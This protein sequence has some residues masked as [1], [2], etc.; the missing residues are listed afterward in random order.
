MKNFLERYH[1][2]EIFGVLILI[3][4]YIKFKGSDSYTTSKYWYGI[5]PNIV[6]FIIPIQ[7]L[8][9]IGGLYWVYQIRKNKPISGLL[10][11]KL[12]GESASEILITIFTVASLIWPWTLPDPK[13]IKLSKA[14]LNT[15]ALWIAATAA[16]LAIAGTFENS[17]STEYQIVA[18]ILFS[19]TIVL[20]DGIGWSANLLYKAIHN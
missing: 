15:S 11:Y 10:T 6:K 4:Y 1:I 13:N 7:L 8:S 3:S 20:I 2:P 17:N 12:F 9:V 18:I 19:I 14:L 5:K 16:I